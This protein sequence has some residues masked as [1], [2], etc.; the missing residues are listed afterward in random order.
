MKKILIIED[1]TFLR[2]MIAGKLKKE[3]F[4]I[5]EAID[6]EEGI[7]KTKEENPD[8]IILDLVLPTL[9]GFEVLSRIKQ[10]KSSSGIP[11][12]ILSNLGQRNEIQHGLDLGAVDYMVKANFTPSEIIKKIVNVLSNNRALNN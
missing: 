11:V 7:R 12:V 10:D 9:D 8:L 6:G 5:I 3:G 1:D 2:E 4:S